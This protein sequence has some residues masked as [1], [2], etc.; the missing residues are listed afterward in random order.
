M[1]RFEA[2]DYLQL[3][4]GGT[5]HRLMRLKDRTIAHNQ[6][7]PDSTQWATWRE[8]RSRGFHNWHGAYA[9]M[10]QGSNGDSP[11]WVTHCGEYFR[12]ERFA[13]ECEGGPDHTGWFTNHDGETFRDGSGKSRGIVARLTHGRFIAGYWWGDNGERVYFPE[14]FTDEADAANAAD[15][16]AEEFAEICRE[17]SE[18]FANVQLAEFDVEEKT[19][20]LQESIALRHRPKIGGFDRVRDAIE[21]LRKA[22]EELT[23]AERAYEGA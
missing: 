16:H 11:V 4:K 9:A 14:I 18:K 20:G 10:S 1:S 2:P 3:L 13:D 8:A 5:R 22:R 12:D 6:N 19:R 17:D 23:E 15:A 21:Q 7:R